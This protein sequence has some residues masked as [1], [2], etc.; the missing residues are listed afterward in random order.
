LGRPINTDLSGVLDD[1]NVP[2]N[3]DGSDKPA[4]LVGPNWVND[5]D[6]LG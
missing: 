1:T 3:P 5:L 6:E 4:D 2:D